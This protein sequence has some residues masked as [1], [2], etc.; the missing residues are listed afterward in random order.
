MLIMKLLVFLLFSF[1]TQY[2]IVVQS[3]LYLL[4]FFHI[5]FVIKC[6]N[7]T[8]IIE[9]FNAWPTLMGLLLNSWTGSAPPTNLVKSNR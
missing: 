4:P 3:N 7:S 5:H 9:P 1:Y 2:S 8:A 6:G